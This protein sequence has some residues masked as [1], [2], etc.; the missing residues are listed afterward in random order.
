[1]GVRISSLTAMA[2]AVATGDLLPLVNVSESSDK[3]KKAT[4]AQ[5]RSAIFPAT[6]SDQSLSDVTTLDV[7]TSKHG[8]VPKAPNDT[9]KYLR[10]D[11]TWATLPAGTAYDMLSTLTA[12]EISITGATTATIS[13]M[14]VCSGTSADYTV[15]LPAVSGN[16][17]KFIGFRMAS[18][19][20]KLVTLDGNGSETIDG[21]TTRVMWANE[22]AILYC[23]GSTWTKVAGKSIPMLCEL[24]GGLVSTGVSTWVGAPLGTSVID[25]TGLMANTANNRITCVRANN[26]IVLF[27]ANFAENNSVIAFTSNVAYV[28]SGPSKNY[29]NPGLGGGIGNV[30][31]HPG[32]SGGY[33]AVSGGVPASLVATDYVALGVIATRNIYCY[34]ALLTLQEVTSW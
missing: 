16:T 24:S 10:G 3:T 15:T 21:A 7:S 18:G 4:I 33:A 2:E 12:S 11:A 8:Y 5:V 29:A 22:A 17:G 30:S 23:D 31:Y 9:A 34:G 19:L 27:Q 28:G 20:T 26:Y 6:E 1:M 25:N 32:L 13:R 14:H